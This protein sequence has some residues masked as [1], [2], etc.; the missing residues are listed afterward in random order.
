MLLLTALP[1]LFVLVAVTSIILGVTRKG[2]PPPIRV[3]YPRHTRGI[4]F[5]MYAYVYRTRQSCFTS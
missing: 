4:K 1:Y 5:Y 3:D 2:T